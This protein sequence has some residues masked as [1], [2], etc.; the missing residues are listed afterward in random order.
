MDLSALVTSLPQDFESA[1][2]QIRALG[3]THVDVVG[4]IERPTSH[5]EALA[6][7]GLLVACAAVGRGLPA[8][9]TLDA[10]D[11]RLRSQAVAHVQDQ[12]TDA[13]QLGATHCYLVPGHNAGHD[14]LMCF[15]D[16]CASLADFAGARMMTLCVEHV[17]GRALPSAAAA[18]QWLR[19]VSHDHLKLLLDV[20]HC[21]ISEED[22]APM[23]VQA[24]EWLGYVH[25]DDNDSVSDL[26]WPLLTGRLTEEM[27]NAVLTLLAMDEFDCGL[28][29]ELNPTNADPITALA[30]GRA[31]V[32]NGLQ[33]K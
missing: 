30:Q 25:L 19:Q 2:L 26:H 14:A 29:L 21:L 32:S 5:R 11:P 1:V 20:G 10:A 3:F 16:A 6:E 24:D 23:M 4:L 33:W 8:G 12:M 9:A 15:A 31:L 13:A 27:L 18:L 17:P 22:P 7:S 28:A